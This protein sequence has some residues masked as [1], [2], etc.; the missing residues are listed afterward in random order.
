MKKLL[1]LGLLAMLCSGCLT[2][3]WAHNRRHFRKVAED[4]RELHE[5][6]DR[7]IFDLESNPME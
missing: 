2:L 1:I 7:T 5:D 4:L 3:N 6:I